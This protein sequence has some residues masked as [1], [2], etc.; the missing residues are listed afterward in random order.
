MS[1]NGGRISV[2]LPRLFTHATRGL[3]TSLPISLAGMTRVKS[4]VGD[5]LADDVCVAGDARP[6]SVRFAVRMR[7]PT[8]ENENYNLLLAVPRDGIVRMST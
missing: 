1:L 4:G 7:W 2:G 8:R 5:G 6:D 3:F